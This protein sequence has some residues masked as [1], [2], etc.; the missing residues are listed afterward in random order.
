MTSI[1]HISSVVLCMLLLYLKQWFVTNLCNRNKRD[2][3]LIFCHNKIY[4]MIWFHQW[5][6]KK[7]VQQNPDLRFVWGTSFLHLP[8]GKIL[9][10]DS[11][12]IKQKITAV[13]KKHYICSKLKLISLFF[14][15]HY[16]D[17]FYIYF[18]GHER[19]SKITAE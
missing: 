11:V 13:V 10:E 5:A 18:M 14:N 4:G 16:I 6:L 2:L 17:I 15:S 12:K 8:L 1:T 7:R 9:Q 19:K 3:F